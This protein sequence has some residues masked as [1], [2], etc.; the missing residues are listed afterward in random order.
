MPFQAGGGLGAAGDAARAARRLPRTPA[1]RTP[2]SFADRSYDARY[3]SPPRRSAAASLP[4]TATSSGLRSAATPRS[5]K[6]SGFRQNSA[7]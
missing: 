6:R 1:A 2:R 4:W 3:A 5:S 7:P